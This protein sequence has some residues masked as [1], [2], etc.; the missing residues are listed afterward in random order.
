[1]PNGVST[2]QQQKILDL[3][4][5]FTKSSK[6]TNN[7]T[8]S[9]QESPKTIEARSQTQKPALEQPQ[10]YYCP[11]MPPRIVGGQG[12]ISS[13]SIDFLRVQEEPESNNSRIVG[14]G[15]S[16]Y[17]W[18][19]ADTCGGLLAKG[20][21]QLVEDKEISYSRL[22]LVP[23]KGGQVINTKQVDLVQPFNM[24]GKLKDATLYW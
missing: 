14:L 23:K 16:K 7:S 8:S 6:D 15:S 4:K 20:A 5:P 1:M 21:I 3:A 13:N 11:N 19:K 18:E 22:F 24:E 2:T 10:Q 17:H 12:N 9:L